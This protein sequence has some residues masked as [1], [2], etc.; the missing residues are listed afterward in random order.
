MLAVSHQIWHFRRGRSEL[1]DRWLSAERKRDVA[2]GRGGSV[3]IAKRA[4]IAGTARNCAKSLPHT[5]QRLTRF[6]SSFE[7]CKFVIVTNDS[8][9]DT[10]NTLRAW[11]ATVP[12][13]LILNLDGLARKARL[14]THRL[15]L[16]RNAY[17]SILKEDLRGGK[18]HELLLVADMDGP[19]ATLVDDPQFVTAIENAP[20][21]WAALLANQRGPYYDIWALRH[22]TWCPD[23]CWEAIQA[24]SKKWFGRRAAREAAKKKYVH[25]K[26]IVIDP[27]APPLKVE[28]A[29]GGFGIYRTEYLT[30]LDYVG[31]TPRGTEVCEHVHFNQM[32]GQKGGSLYIVPALLNL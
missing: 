9:D 1:C 12:N 17:L 30:D 19:N 25:D 26:Q 13:A 5:L 28:S 22:P 14:R 8:D 18:G 2:D 11:A 23:D 32:I 29:F 6:Q 16:A 27:S 24:A 20:S 15:A 21:D 31:L 10:E 3:M 7:Q 4:F